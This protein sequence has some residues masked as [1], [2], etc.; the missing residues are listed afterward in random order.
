MCGG[1]IY[2]VMS[3]VFVMVKDLKKEKK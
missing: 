3:P 1:K 2:S